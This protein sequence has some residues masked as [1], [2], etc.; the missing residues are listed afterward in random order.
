MK[1]ALLIG[2]R[3]AGK[4]ST[5]EVL[6]RSVSVI[7]LDRRFEEEAGQRIHEFVAE[8]GEKAFRARETELLRGA[9]EECRR[10]IHLLVPGGGVVE[11]NQKELAA[12]PFPRIWIPVAMEEAWSRLQGEPDR[13]QVGGWHRKE[14]FEEAFRRREVLY[15]RLATHRTS[16]GSPETIA[17]EIMGIMKES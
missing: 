5:A 1:S 6:R 9:L 7:D 2:F 16:S 4:S 17:G 8:R 15:A 14:V 13:L 11:E 3:G 12:W 10:S